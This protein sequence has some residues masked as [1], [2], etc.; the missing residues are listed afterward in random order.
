MRNPPIL[1]CSIANGKNDQLPCYH[2]SDKNAT[3]FFPRKWTR[4]RAARP[5]AI[6][7]GIDSVFFTPRGTIAMTTEQGGENDG[8][9]QHHERPGGPRG[10]EQ[11][12]V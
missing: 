4:M 12:E 5:L 6:H 1:D 10:A 9:E 7:P 3:S 11:H 8:E 2:K